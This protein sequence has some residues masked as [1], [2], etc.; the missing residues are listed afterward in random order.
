M[1]AIPT[2][3]RSVKGRR[4]VAP[5]LWSMTRDSVFDDWDDP[6]EC[7]DLWSREISRDGSLEPT[8]DAR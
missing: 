1:T 8:E 4:G 6:G 5:S 2:L 3:T 7:L